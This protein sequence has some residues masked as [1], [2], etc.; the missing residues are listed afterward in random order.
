MAITYTDFLA[1]VRSY[2]EVDSNVLSDT[3]ID[4]FIRHTELDVA[5]KVDYDDIRKY[6]TSNFN[7]NKKI[8]N[9]AICI[10][11]NK[12]ITS[13]CIFIIIFC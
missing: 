7:A 10:F 11:S 6:A 5:G 12:I 4:Q 2:T 1:Q 3:L 9:N 8:L 13:F